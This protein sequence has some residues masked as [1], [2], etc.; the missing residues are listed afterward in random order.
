MLHKTS[1]SQ[2]LHILI[3]LVTA[4]LLPLFVSCSDS[5][6]PEPA[7]SHR[8]V[9]VYMAA[10]N[11]LGSA[12]FDK[13]DL[14]EMQSAV[15]A[16]QLDGGRL[17]VFHAG[18]SGDYKLLEITPEEIVTLKMYN[19]NGEHSS[20]SAKFMSQVIDDT[21]RLAPADS[22]GL[23]LWS[24]GL[25]WLQNGITDDFAD[26]ISSQSWGEERGRTMNI[27]SLAAALSGKNL[28]F[29]YFD[30]CFMA[31]V[32]VAYEL[33]HVTPLI[34]ASAIEIPVDGMPYDRNI[35]PLFARPQA[36]LVSAAK[37]TF[38]YYNVLS[39]EN[40]TCAMSV[41]ST[42]GLDRLAEISRQILASSSGRV[43]DGFTP[44]RFMT[45]GRC[46]FYDMG[47]Y[48]HALTENCA[49]SALADSWDDA[50]DNCI[51]YAS[52]TPRLW[53]RLYIEHHCG[54][55][56]YIPAEG[57]TSIKNYNT[58]KWYTDV[59]APAISAK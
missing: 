37:N 7:K 42:D 17:L 56:T 38:D 23:V 36:D 19:E 21:K 57:D 26:G 49:D 5:P 13:L 2:F 29:V 50:L 55:S 27:S 28:D 34:V 48:Y 24:H 45:E 31:S 41:I 15:R 3:C 39:G 25:G 14:D 54:L 40:R 8:T 46:W 1:V 20:V 47:H 16:G 52:A 4:L 44:Q 32:E 9:L 33:R 11:S 51:M 18:T 30:C 53:N 22:Y 35:A 12:G 6:E 58:L 10:C 43:P 59:V